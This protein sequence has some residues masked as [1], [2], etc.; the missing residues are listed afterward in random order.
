MCL[1]RCGNRKFLAGPIDA[2]PGPCP[3]AA[4]VE[5]VLPVEPAPAPPKSSM[6]ACP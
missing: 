3:R 4:S 1:E 5:G 6:A 2:L